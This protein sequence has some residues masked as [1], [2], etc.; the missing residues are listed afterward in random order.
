MKEFYYISASA[1]AGK[2]NWAVNELAEKLQV[3]QYNILMVCPTIDLCNQIV[4]SSAN[5]FKTIH[6]ENTTGSA[7]SAIQDVFRQK[8]GPVALAITEAAFMKLPESINTAN[9]IVIKDEASEPLSVHTINC[10]DSWSLLE[11]WFKL[12]KLDSSNGLRN[13]F[14]AVGINSECPETTTGADGITGAIHDLR[15][16]ILNSN[17]D[18]LMDPTRMNCEHPQFC[19][20]TFIK[21]SM[22]ERFA[23]TYFMSANFEHTFLYHQWASQGVK[24][25]DRTPDK[26]QV[27]PDSSR[28]TIHY[29]R[30]DGC[31]SRARREGNGQLSGYINWINQE[32]PNGDYIYVRNESDAKRSEFSILKGEQIPAVCHGLNNWRDQTKFVSFASYLVSNHSEPYYQYY[33]TS[34]TDARSLRN[35]QMIYQQLTRTDLRN[36]KSNKPIDVYLPTLADA[37]ELLI[38]MPGAKIIDLHK[39]SP[40]QVTGTTGTLKS[41]WL[42]TNTPEKQASQL[43]ALYSMGAKTYAYVNASFTK[44]ELTI[45]S[46]PLVGENEGGNIIFG[47]VFSPTNGENAGY[48]SSRKSKRK[49]HPLINYIRRYKKPDVQGLSKKQLKQFKRNG[50][51]FFITGILPEKSRFSK[52]NIQG[53]NDIIAF[54]FDDSEFTSRDISRVFRG[55]EYL[56]YTTIS[57]DH[58]TGLSRFRVVLPCSRVMSIS[59]HK[60]LMEY[61]QQEIAN[62]AKEI[63]RT[64]GLDECCL[65]PE[66]KFYLPHKESEIRHLTEDKMV[67]D[68]DLLLAKKTRKAIVELPTVD[69]LCMTGSASK[70]KTGSVMAR[71]QQLIDEMRP[72]DRS[73]KA[74]QV[75]GILGRSGLDIVV[76]GQVISQLIGRGV[77]V[78]TIK[79]AKKYAGLW[80]AA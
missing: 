21:P 65:G 29:W 42:P 32:L 49:I 56:T 72:G 18:V 39:S 79:S 6:S 5:R 75:G 14:R 27:K 51:P 22:Y 77:D 48:R 10:T 61:F 74:V 40:G 3:R 4:T 15:Q 23:Q 66:R 63:G 35:T 57:N 69:D 25:T 8:S 54:D 55:L 13:L 76:K 7:V 11:K 71:C 70:M 47:G 44:E 67:L 30:D 59:E 64:S 36:F 20:S 38:Y 28:V 9:W 80:A 31:W 73:R 41:N 78:G 24:W 26:L 12:K 45:G 16:G 43:T 19:Y 62:Y 53:N 2:T 60:R 1:G 17:V 37:L 52:E 68:V 46:P 34:T 58:S 33:G 50:L